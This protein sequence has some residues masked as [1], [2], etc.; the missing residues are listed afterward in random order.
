MESTSVSDIRLLIIA[1]DDETRTC[2]LKYFQA[3]KYQTTT[4][5]DA[6][7]ALR[8]LSNTPGY[9]IAL[10][11]VSLPGKNGFDLLEAA[12][13]YPI[14]TAFLLIT[15]RSCLEDKLQGFHLGADDYVVKP[16]AMEE[17]EAR[18]HAVLRRRPA[19]T[20]STDQNIYTLNDLTI[21]FAANT[22]FREERR[23]PL[24]SLEFNI[25][26]YLVE[27]RGRVVR[28]EELRDAVWADRDGICLR[29]ID[30]HVAK[31]REKLEQDPDVPAYLQTVY[32]KGYE[33]AC[34]EYA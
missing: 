24:T 25:L 8:Y 6:D 19:P 7:T 18:V 27:H 2:L 28:R 32:G 1:G 26:E 33:F 34:A 3:S 15:D 29:T 12:K 23:I 16:C 21:D 14:D 22:C 11:D 17:L 30:R 13:K 4:V 10:L 31:I 9:D 20:T 5:G